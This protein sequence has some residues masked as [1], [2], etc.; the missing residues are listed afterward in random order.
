MTNV[1]DLK[2]HFFGWNNEDKHDKIWGTISIG[3]NNYCFWG[4]R[5]QDKLNKI[6]FKKYPDGRTGLW[7][8]QDMARKKENKGY[9]RITVDTVNGVYVGPEH[10]SPGITQ[11]LINCLLV[12]RLSDNFR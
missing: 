1:T 10:V 9:D 7:E 6:M 3:T 5:G 11:H 8:L 12:A 2:I 4:P